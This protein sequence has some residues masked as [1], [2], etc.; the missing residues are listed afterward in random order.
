MGHK[1]RVV[2]SASVGEYTFEEISDPGNVVPGNMFR[3]TIEG[4]DNRSGSEYYPS[5]D[6]A[7]AAAIAEK[8]TGRRGAG[9]AGGTGVGTAADWFM[10]MIGADKDD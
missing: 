4:R 7:M 6:Y 8:H 3:Y 10:R 2:S 9:G 5:L 1:D